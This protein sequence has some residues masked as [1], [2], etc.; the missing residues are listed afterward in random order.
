MGHNNPPKD[1]TFKKR[2]AQ[3][4]F[5]HPEKPAGAV[6][7]GFKLYTEMD[8]AGCGA[9]VSDREFSD[10][11]G[12]SE[13]AVQNFKRWLL[14]ACFVRIQVKGARG[15]A[16]AFMAVIPGEELPAPHAVIQNVIAA[17]ITGREDEHRH[18]MPA[19][20]QVIPAIRAVNAEIAAPNAGIPPRALALIES[21][22][23][24]DS[25]KL[26]EVSEVKEGGAGAPTPL[27][28]LA[29]FEAYNQLAQRLGLS[30]ARTL[31]PQRRKS[32]IARMREHGGVSAWATALANIERSAF[33]QGENDR[34]WRLDFDFMLQAKSFTRLVEGGYG[35]GAHAKVKEGEFDKIGRLV[36]QATENQQRRLDH[37]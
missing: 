25:Y 2:W 5:S 16:N 36:R 20:E 14:N 34:G 22:L 4:L 28:A 8:M 30:V 33:L 21:S 17:S 7:M 37:E 24:E 19:I 13:R 31:T 32:I 35:N 23:R 3:T 15:R 27:D 12:I 6:A 10:S 11:C 18:L 1:R 9:V 26:E 29:G